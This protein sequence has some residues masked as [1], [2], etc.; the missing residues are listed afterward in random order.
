MT[1]VTDS[2][3]NEL[4][5]E[6]AFEKYLQPIHDSRDSFHKKAKIYTYKNFI[7]L[8]SYETIVA[9]IEKTENNEEF[10]T[11]LGYYSS[12]TSRHVNEFLRQYGFIDKNIP[13]KAYNNTDGLMF[14]KGAK[15]L[16]N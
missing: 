12:T 11:V 2:F 3:L 9:Y 15:N 4:K 7:Y 5:V 14:K 1:F 16:C 6:G 10:A 13:K 8:V